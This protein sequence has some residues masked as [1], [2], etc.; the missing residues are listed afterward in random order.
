MPSPS[1]TY[2]Y[3]SRRAEYYTGISVVRPCAPRKRS[4]RLRIFWE[5]RMATLLL[6]AAIFWTLQIITGNLNRNALWQTPGPAEVG[7]A[8]IVLWFHA[9]WRRLL[10]AE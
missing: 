10:K 3:E 9:K 1:P 4:F 5:E 6:V 2:D 7:V 8:G